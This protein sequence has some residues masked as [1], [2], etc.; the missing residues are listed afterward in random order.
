[1]MWICGFFSPVRIGMFY[2]IRTLN[3]SQVATLENAVRDATRSARSD[4]DTDIV[5]IF[6]VRA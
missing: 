1:M 6:V 4:D 3:M 5:V 2:V